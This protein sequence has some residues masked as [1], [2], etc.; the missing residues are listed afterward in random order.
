MTLL[1]KR[2]ATA[3][4]ALAKDKG[5][6]D[7]VASDMAA[8]H[9]ELHAPGASALLTSPDVSVAE[10]TE[11]LGKLTAGRHELVANL[12]G[13]LQ[14]RR[15]LEVLA[16]MPTAYRDLFMQDRGEVEGV[17]ESAHPL[18][19]DELTAL[20]TLANRLSGKK[21][22]LTSKH[23]P[24]LLGGVRLIVGNVLYDGSLRAALTQLQDKLQQSSV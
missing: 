14:R 24:D 21:C 15:R 22:L 5:A 13:V 23:N 20:T 16:D 7:A 18:S 9:G 12:V 19:A 6:A 11:V 8:L 17:A 2:Y 4:F 10:R 1:A 3:L